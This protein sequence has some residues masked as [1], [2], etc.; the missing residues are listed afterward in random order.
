MLKDR[1]R[2][3]LNKRRRDRVVVMAWMSWR[4]RRKFQFQF[5][6]EKQNHDGPFRQRLTEPVPSP[7]S[8][9][10]CRRVGCGHLVPSFHSCHSVVVVN[11]HPYKKPRHREP[12][13]PPFSSDG[14]RVGG[15]PRRSRPSLT[16]VVTDNISTS[17]S[18]RPG[19]QRRHV[20]VTAHALGHCGSPGRIR[21]AAVSD[22]I[23]DGHREDTRGRATVSQGRGRRRRAMGKPGFCLPRTVASNM[24]RVDGV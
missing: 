2:G 21:H 1:R 6:E 20:G 16:R 9:R 3:R 7:S 10:R 24:S 12:S 4:L 11:R 23:G 17:R 22:C 5:K 14:L 18:S 15:R 13:I 19:Q 8:P